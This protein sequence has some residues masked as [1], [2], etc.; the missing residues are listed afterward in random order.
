[1]SAHG[2]VQTAVEATQLG[3]YDYLEKPVSAGRLE[4]TLR[5]AVNS[6]S[7]TPTVGESVT[8]TS[9]EISIVGTSEEIDTLRPP[10]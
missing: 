8:K 3:A 9:P 7:P 4:I 5:N 2:T 6:I 1:M 10:N